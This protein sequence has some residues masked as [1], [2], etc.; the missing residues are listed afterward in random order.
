MGD[1]G[2]NTIESILQFVA[3]LA[4][5]FPGQDTNNT[6]FEGGAPSLDGGL[7]IAGRRQHL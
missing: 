1:R 2:R 4:A 7:A 5:V 6:D 3:M